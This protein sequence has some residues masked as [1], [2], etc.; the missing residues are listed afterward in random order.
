MTMK[1][2]DFPLASQLLRPV[3]VALDEARS[4]SATLN[5]D[6]EEAFKA[7]TATLEEGK[8]KK[9]DSAAPKVKTQ[10]GGEKIEETRTVPIAAVKDSL[11][12]V[13]IVRASQTIT[14][15]LHDHQVRAIATS[16]Y[17]IMCIRRI[18]DG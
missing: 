16:F 10:E 15:T 12:G 11:E 6:R 7:L 1:L 17:L 18:A 14:A 2:S 9:E 13:T 4:E 8:G 5:Q 3:Q